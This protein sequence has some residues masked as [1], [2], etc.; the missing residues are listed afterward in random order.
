MPGMIDCHWHS[1][2]TSMTVPKLMN[3]DMSYIGIKGAVGAKETLL[4]GF[5]SVRDVGGAVFG[6]KKATDEGI[7]EG[8]RV[9]PSGGKY[10]KWIYTNINKY[11]EG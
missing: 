5:T 4:R 6:L 9:Y 11:S 7:I 8:P 3:S 10:G 2:F 1:L